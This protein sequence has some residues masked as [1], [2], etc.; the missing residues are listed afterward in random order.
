MDPLS[1]ISGGAG[2]FSGSSSATTGNADVKSATGT[3]NFNIGGNP[4]ITGVLGDPVKLAII[5]AV[6]VVGFI[7]WRKWR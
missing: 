2:G 7:A 5:G 6:V 3:K 4:N 1:L